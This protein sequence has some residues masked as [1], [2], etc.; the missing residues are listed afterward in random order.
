VHPGITTASLFVFLC[1]NFLLHP[2]GSV[3]HLHRSEQKIF[4]V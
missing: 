1:D 4:E 3:E 2:D